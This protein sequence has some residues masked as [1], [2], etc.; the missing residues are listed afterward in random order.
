MAIT[1]KLPTRAGALEDYTLAGTAPVQPA[2][3]VKF[4]RIA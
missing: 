4:N 2:A 3:G 1:L